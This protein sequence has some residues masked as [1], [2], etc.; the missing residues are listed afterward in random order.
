MYGQQRVEVGGEGNELEE[1]SS[2]TNLFLGG[3]TRSWRQ[4]AVERC[5]SGNKHYFIRKFGNVFPHFRQI[6]QINGIGKKEID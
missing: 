1:N 2:G 3:H 4:Q 6:V 5:Q